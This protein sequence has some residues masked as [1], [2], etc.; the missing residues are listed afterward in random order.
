MGWEAWDELSDCRSARAGEK[1]KS[2]GEKGSSVD[3]A[4]KKREKF[5][6]ILH[7]YGWG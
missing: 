2:K 7:V 3:G 1:C 6:L 4:V 5:S